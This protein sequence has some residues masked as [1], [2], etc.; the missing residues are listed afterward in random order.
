V[1]TNSIETQLSV[2][3]VGAKGDSIAALAR[4]HIKPLDIEGIVA[5]DISTNASASSSGTIHF[6]LTAFNMLL[7]L[8]L[9]R[10]S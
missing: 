3:A 8:H 7:F 2:K 4:Y 9:L 1:F 5:A 6:A 10:F